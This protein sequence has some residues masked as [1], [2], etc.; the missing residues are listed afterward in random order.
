[1]NE[2]ITSNFQALIFWLLVFGVFMLWE[3]VT[4]ITRLRRDFEQFHFTFRQHF[5]RQ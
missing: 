5:P 4:E 3:I 2:W 1:M